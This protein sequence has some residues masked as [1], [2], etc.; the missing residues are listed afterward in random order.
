LPIRISR[1]V[2]P[3]VAVTNAIIKIP[4]RSSF[5]FIAARAPEMAKAAV[6]NRSRMVKSDKSILAPKGRLSG[7]KLNPSLRVLF[8]VLVAIGMPGNCKLI[9]LI[10]RCASLPAKAGLQQII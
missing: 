4:K 6:P 8:P 9:F 3:P 5:L 2:P 7:E 10:H 1:I